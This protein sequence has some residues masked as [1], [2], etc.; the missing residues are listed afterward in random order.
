ME[1][2]SALIFNAAHDPPLVTWNLIRKLTA[3]ALLLLFFPS[4]YLYLY[5]F[6]FSFLNSILCV[7]VCACHCCFFLAPISTP[8]NM[9][10]AHPLRRFIEPGGPGVGPAPAGSGGLRRAPAGSG[11]G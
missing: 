3:I 4:E 11:G 5:S 9:S 10:N 7:C 2:R 6:F 8:I 1:G